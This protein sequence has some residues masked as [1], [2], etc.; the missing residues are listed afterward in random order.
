MKLKLRR[1]RSL[2][3]ARHGQSLRNIAESKGPF[4]KDEQ[5]REKYGNYSDHLIPLTEKGLKQARSLGKKLKKQFGIFDYVIH[6]G[7]QR[8]R[9]TA[10]GILEAYS[11]N[12]LKVMSVSE[13]LLI[14]ERDPGYFINLTEA[15]VK[16]N[17]P[18]WGNH[19]FYS[20][21]FLVVPFGGESV[22]KMCE[23]RLSEFLRRL[24]EELPATDHRSN[25]LLVSHGRTT[26][27]LRYLLEGWS[28]ERMNHEIRHGNPPNCSV[29]HYKF[30]VCGQAQ[31]QFANKVFK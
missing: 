6:S 15:E 4:F 3:L 5:Q 13:N 22:A 25:V 14:R 20:D 28:H 16:E 29:T 12:E 24:D 8:A 9:Q 21:P 7:F 10:S 1:I 11:E 18:W 31:L 23:G 19:W 17:W 30:D 26:L 27:G 2:F